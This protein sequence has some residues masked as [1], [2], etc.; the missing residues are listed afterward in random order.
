MSASQAPEAHEVRDWVVEALEDMKA[1]DVACLPVGKTSTIA[2]FFVIC[3]GTSET[4]CRAIAQEV[5]RKLKEQSLSP[6]NAGEPGSGAWTL[7]DFG[8]VVLHVFSR[9]ARGRY[10][11]EDVWGGG[12]EHVGTAD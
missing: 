9:E 4:H 5:A 11:L 12:G 7:L 8:S 6:L 2:D 10:A 1:L 3:S